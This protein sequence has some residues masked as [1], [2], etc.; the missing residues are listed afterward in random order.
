MGKPQD[1]TNIVI[2]SARA[3]IINILLAGTV[4]NI[5]WTYLCK[6]YDAKLCM[7]EH[8]QGLFIFEKDHEGACRFHFVF[9]DA[10]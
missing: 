5:Y 1:F 8:S 9:Q 10:C 2:N 3:Y 6:L 4:T 7:A